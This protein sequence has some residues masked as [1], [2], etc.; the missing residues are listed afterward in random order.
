LADLAKFPHLRPKD[1]KNIL[2]SMPKTLEST[3]S[4]I[5]LKVPEGLTAEAAKALQWISLSLRPLTLEEVNEACIVNPKDSPILDEQDRLTVDGIVSSLPC[6]L[7]RSIGQA[8]ILFLSHISVKEFLTSPMIQNSPCASYGFQCGRA[9]SFI[10]ESCIAYIN[11]WLVNSPKTKTYEEQELQQFPLLRYACRYWSDHFNL[12]DAEGQV[13]LTPAVIKLLRSKEYQTEILTIFNP[14]SRSNDFFDAHWALLHPLGWSAALGLTLVAEMLLRESKDHINSEQDV[15]LPLPAMMYRC[16]YNK[17]PYPYRRN[18]SGTPL[19]KA[20]QSNHPEVAL[21]LIKHGADIHM[22]GQE[23][24]TALSIACLGGRESL[25]RLLLEN[26]ADPNEKFR[27]STPLIYAIESRELTVCE[28][29]LDRGALV[30]GPVSDDDTLLMRAAIVDE[31]EIVKLLLDRGADVNQQVER[32]VARIRD[33]ARDY[34]DAL[35]VAAMYGSVDMVKILLSRGA[36]ISPSALAYSLTGLEDGPLESHRQICEIFVQHGADLNPDMTEY[37][38]PLVMALHNMWYDIAE[39]MMDKGALVQPDDPT[40]RTA[41]N[42]LV[43]SIHNI[44]ILTRIL[45]LGI[46]VNAPVALLQ[47]WAWEGWDMIRH[48]ATAL[49]AAA[50]HL[51]IE[52]VRFLL[53]RGADITI[54]GPPFGNALFA[55][56]AGTMTGLELNPDPWSIERK[57][58]L[59]I[60]TK[61][62]AKDICAMLVNSKPNTLDLG[63]PWEF[64]NYDCFCMAMEGL[65]EL[66]EI[67]IPISESQFYA[68]VLHSLTNT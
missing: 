11:H 13:R 38:A 39:S 43:A 37:D 6:L 68:M 26:G 60:R 9:H 65:R 31:L 41:G 4:Q 67:D 25:V 55:A 46:D 28:M 30:Q 44:E 50:Y 34:P 64:I 24:Y 10:A 5:L 61:Q 22:K 66:F 56:F 12:A 45:D 19:M 36:R 14:I 15:V 2:D 35:S 7:N 3:Y 40:C 33:P 48:F 63:V 42:I 23:G 57:K 54:Q 49:Q 53:D 27:D 16:E 29:L 32:K 17:D 47:S 8:N 51:E 58:D 18:I 21:L 20:V 52:T 59:D 1:I 62:T